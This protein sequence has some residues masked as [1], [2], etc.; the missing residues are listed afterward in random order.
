MHQLIHQQS[1]VLFLLHLS[2]LEIHLLKLF[3]SLVQLRLDLVVLDEGHLTRA[4]PVHFL[5]LFLQFEQL[6]RLIV[7]ETT[8]DLLL[9]LSAFLL[10][11]ILLNLLFFFA[12]LLALLDFR[13]F[14]HMF[15][16]LVHELILLLLLLDLHFVF[17]FNADALR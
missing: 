13:A 7:L 2:A 3:P 4:N 14:E 10:L 8:L 9:P 6:L 1:L 11:V 17:D 5:T 15:L 16:I 12:A